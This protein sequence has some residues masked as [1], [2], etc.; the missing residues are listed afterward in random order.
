[1]PKTSLAVLIALLLCCSA[2][3]ASAAEK[4]QVLALMSDDAVPE[5]LTLTEELK[6]A[7]E[8]EPELE[9]VPGEYAL[10]VLL[11][12]LA[13]REPPDA[14][15]FK[16]I[17]AKIGTVNFA[18]GRLARDGDELVLELHLWQ[19]ERESSRAELRYTPSTSQ[20]AN[21]DAARAAIA[22]LLEERGSS[23]A[24]PGR[25]PAPDDRVAA[26]SSE[27]SA[28][29][30]ARPTSK[31]PIA[32]YVL[33][34]S[35]LVLAGG[36]VYSALRVD[37]FSDSGDFRAYRAGVPQGLDACREAEQGY[38]VSGAPSPG[39]VENDCKSAKTFHVL[40]YVFFGVGAA[41]AATGTVLVLTHDR[42][43]PRAAGSALP[44]F[45][46][47]P[48]SARVTLDVAF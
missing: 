11:V 10:E 46:L 24:P 41:A 3:A 47:T 28:Y 26:L 27:E 12:A 1:V 21:A 5:A 31:T 29:G 13:C 43:S 7:V 22:K 15:C 17:A 2:N 35:G 16:R 42:G 9:L 8:S 38:V 48:Q 4:L 23:L 45:A 6:R 34:A 19:K 37:G 25:T 33:L 18:W 44:R 20:T 36:G 14:A 32:G 39:Q 40:Q 30:E